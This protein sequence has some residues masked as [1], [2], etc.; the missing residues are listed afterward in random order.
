MYRLLWQA[1]LYGNKVAP[2]LVKPHEKFSKNFLKYV[3]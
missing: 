3:L 1:I 2:L